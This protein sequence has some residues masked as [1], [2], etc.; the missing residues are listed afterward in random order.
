MAYGF[1]NS[2][3]V[4]MGAITTQLLGGLAE[5]VGLGLCFAFMGAI[6]IVALA[7]QLIVL[8]PR[9]D[10]ADDDEEELQAQEAV[11]EDL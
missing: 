1:M 9:H 6:L 10:D 7:L 4:F 5:S 8:H 3:G 11:A 2:V